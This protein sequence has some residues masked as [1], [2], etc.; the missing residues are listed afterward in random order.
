MDKSTNTALLNLTKVL[1]LSVQ[2]SSIMP[3]ITLLEMG[4]FIFTFI[5]DD[6]FKKWLVHK[7]KFFINSYLYMILGSQFGEKQKN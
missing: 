3:K 7:I 2:K 6:N 5:P 1:E 4:L